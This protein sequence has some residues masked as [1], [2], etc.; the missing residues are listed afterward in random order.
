M[1]SKLSGADQRTYH[2]IF[3]HPMSHNIEWSEVHSMFKSLGEVVE[4]HNGNTKITRNGHTLVMHQASP[5]TIIEPSV[6]MK[7][8]H[9]L[10][11]SREEEGTSAPAGDHLLLVI[12][13]HEARIFKSELPGSVPEK[14]VPY[15][16]HGYGQH[17][18]NVHDPADGQQ[19]PIPKSFFEAIGKSLAGASQILIFGNGS[20]G[21]TAMSELMDYLHS[22]EKLLFEH[23]I[24]TVSVDEHHMTEDQL[25]AKARE[26]YKPD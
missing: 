22:S 3:S 18:H 1:S 9:F 11:S 19:H 24:G 5:N 23:V 15:D 2:S 14:I 13:H 20:G 7:V 4:E 26:F 6:L 10:R 17:L 12:D 16:P 25:L 8:R 21:G